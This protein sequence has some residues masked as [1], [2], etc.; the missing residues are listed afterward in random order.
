MRCPAAALAALAALAVPASAHAQT[1]SSPTASA[2]EAR[3]E[4]AQLPADSLERARKYA[5]W[6]LTARTDSMF[7]HFDSVSRQQYGSPSV[8]DEV[9]ADLAIRA[10]SEERVLEERWVDRLGKRQYWRTSRFTGSDEPVMIPLALLPTGAL[11]GIGINRQS[12]A[13]PVDP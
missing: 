12:E 4:L 13:P 8:L 7:A 1:A 5:T 9:A 10:G 6:F 11:A 2:A 3:R